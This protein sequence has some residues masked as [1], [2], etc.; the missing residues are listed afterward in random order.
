MMPLLLSTL[1]RGMVDEIISNEAFHRYGLTDRPEN[2]II[3]I[4][5]FTKQHISHKSIR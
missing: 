4:A 2:K 3:C 1:A 5:I